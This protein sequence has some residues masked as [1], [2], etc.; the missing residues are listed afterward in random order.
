MA[1]PRLEIVCGKGGVGKSTLSVALGLQRALRGESILVVTSHPLEELA[2]SVS[3]EGLEQQVEVADRF[4]VIHID[5]KRV[6]AQRVRQT[7]PSSAM[8]SV[9]TKSRIYNSLI[10]IAPGIKEL[11]FLSR[12]RQL[13]EDDSPHSYDGIIWDAPATGHFLQVMKVA[14]NF[15]AYL[16]GPFAREGRDL[17]RFF[18]S[19]D[20]R[21]YSVVL[22]QEM[23]IQETV[24]LGQE[25]ATLDLAPDRVLCNAVSPLAGLDIDQIEEVFSEWEAADLPAPARGF[26]QAKI[27]LE[28][29]LYQKLESRLRR[30]VVRLP[31]LAFFN[32]AT[33]PVLTELGRRLL[34]G[35]DSPERK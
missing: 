7:M 21:I 30:P 6:L 8:A 4:F 2:L 24:E 5:S 23:V 25:L 3:V 35:I 32:T 31:R 26:M 29:E 28:F 9:V 13:A 19:I 34:D 12:I 1:E 22:L 16:T 11:A 15:E 10:E 17:K 33:L 18:E 27:L 20:K 14:Q